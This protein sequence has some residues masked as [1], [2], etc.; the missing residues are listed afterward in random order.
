MSWFREESYGDSNRS[1]TRQLFYRSV[2]RHSTVARA[3]G[4][5]D[6]HTRSGLM[7]WLHSSLQF[8]YINPYS[9]FITFSIYKPKQ[10]KSSHLVPSKHKFCK[11][12]NINRSQCNT[13]FLKINNVK[14]NYSGSLV[15]MNYIIQW[16]VNLVDPFC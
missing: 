15:I 9:I 7:S 14:W 5:D 11:A 10:Y 1:S 12:R 2:Y 6:L 4:L 3:P 16:Y 8:S 13:F